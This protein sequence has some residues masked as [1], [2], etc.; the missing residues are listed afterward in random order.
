M[1]Q[2]PH[3]YWDAA[4]ARN[5]VVLRVIVV[6]L[7]G[8]LAGHGGLDAVMVPR[9][10]RSII[11]RVLRPAESALRRMIVIAARDVKVEPSSPKADLSQSVAG[12]ITAKTFTPGRTS[13]LAFQLFDPRKRFG[14]RRIEYTSLNPRVFF[15][16]AGP[17]FSPLSQHLASGPGT[18]PEPEPENQTGARRL[19]L[20]L[21]A[22]SAALEDVPR[23]AKRLVRLRA[24]RE[25]KKSIISPLRLGKPPGHR[26]IPVDEVDLV[27][28]ECH[29][30]AIAVLT[31]PPNTS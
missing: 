26:N 14:Q 8:L 20:R 12:K 7:L 10:V 6:E 30:F 5:I 23:Q 19:C 13:R 1:F 21:K 3:H 17:P 9:G 22:L 15:I 25:H 4:V 28:A 2:L 27:L 31:A 16:A 29:D 18:L 11:L 24:L